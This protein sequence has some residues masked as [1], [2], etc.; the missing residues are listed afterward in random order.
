MISVCSGD[1]A[2]KASIG[3]A[4][5]Q[6]I[7]EYIFQFQIPAAFLQRIGF[8]SQ[9]F[10]VIQYQITDGN[11]SSIAGRNNDVTFTEHIV[12]A[13]TVASCGTGWA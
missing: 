3:T 5:F 12:A 13:V 9:D 8:L 6:Y 10:D 11:I 4:E 2:D 7:I 1:T